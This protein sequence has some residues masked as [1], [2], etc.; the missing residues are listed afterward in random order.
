MTLATRA[1]PFPDVQHLLQMHTLP[2]LLLLPKLVQ[3]FCCTGSGSL[4]NAAPALRRQC[5]HGGVPHRLHL[6]RRPEA[7]RSST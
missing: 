2:V 7:R 5:Q 1:P 3:H 6:A 4:P